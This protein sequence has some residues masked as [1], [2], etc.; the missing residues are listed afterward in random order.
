VVA[1]AVRSCRTHAANTHTHRRA[2]GRDAAL[3]DAMMARLYY[4][5]IHIL[6]IMASVTVMAACCAGL[7]QPTRRGARHPR[8]RTAGVPRRGAPFKIQK[9][10]GGGGRA[11]LRAPRRPGR[12]LRA[13]RS[14]SGACG[15][16]WGTSTPGRRAASFARSPPRAAAPSWEAFWVQSPPPGR[17]VARARAESRL[18]ACVCRRLPHAGRV[19]LSRAARRAVRLLRKTGCA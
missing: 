7:L 18:R 2:S 14:S 5:S 6:F 15:P 13:P 11:Q 4:L 19:A 9:L 1:A 3:Q 16:P 8:R 10:K 12:P 17:C